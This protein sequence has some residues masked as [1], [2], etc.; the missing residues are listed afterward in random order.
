MHNMTCRVHVDSS[1]QPRW[2]SHQSSSHWSHIVHDIS[3]ASIG[4]IMEYR[5]NVLDKLFA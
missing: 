2:M 1:S 5:L 3:K 4:V